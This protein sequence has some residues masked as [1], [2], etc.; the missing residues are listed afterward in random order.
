MLIT[1]RQAE[2]LLK[3]VVHDLRQPLGN[4]ETSAYLL[5]RILRG[6]E[7][8]ADPHLTMI[9]RQVDLA[10]SILNNAVEELYHLHAQ[11]TEA[12]SLAFT[13]SA[14]AAVT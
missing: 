5:H 8:Q 4:I 1:D 7:G 14:T 2:K 11:P 6:S 3:N 10:V 9:E 12:E 13:K